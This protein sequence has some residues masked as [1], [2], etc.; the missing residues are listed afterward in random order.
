MECQHEPVVDETMVGVRVRDVED[1]V[2]ASL[3]ELRS[4]RDGDWSR[5]AGSMTWDCRKVLEH[6]ADDL[7]IYGTQLI[8]QVPTAYLPLEIKIPEAT[9]TAE[10]IEGLRG[11]AAVFVG[12]LRAAPPSARG[13]HPSGLADVEATAA[14]GIVEVMI[15]TYD[16]S[17]GLGHT[18]VGPQ[19]SSRRVLA[20]IFPDVEPVSDSW[21]TLL[22]AAGRIELPGR[23]RRSSW[24]WYNDW[25]G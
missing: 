14:M 21:V 1:A 5:P 9:G 4:L 7:I 25:S 6:V 16:I 10:A 23:P 22:W 19:E 11:A 24:R 18:W 8:A 12:L 17:Q 13:W 20:R 15:H 3:A 2:D